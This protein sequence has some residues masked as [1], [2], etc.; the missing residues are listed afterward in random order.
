LLNCTPSWK[1][2]TIA[3][4]TIAITHVFFE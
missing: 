1:Q 4:T 3:I 2:K